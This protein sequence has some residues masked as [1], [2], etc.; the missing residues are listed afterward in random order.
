[1]AVEAHRGHVAQVQLNSGDGCT[2]RNIA[3]ELYSYPAKG[4]GPVRRVMR[5]SYSG[6]RGIVA[7]DS[8]DRID[9]GYMTLSN[10]K[11]DRKGSQSRSSRSQLATTLVPFDGITMS[12]QTGW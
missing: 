8:E 6:I 4:D 10:N 11:Y 5:S 7:G 1:M 2:V 3:A 12:L 9:G